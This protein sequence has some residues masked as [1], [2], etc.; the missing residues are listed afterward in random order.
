MNTSGEEERAVL[1]LNTNSPTTNSTDSSSSNTALSSTQTNMDTTLSTSTHY[2][3]PSNSNKTPTRQNQQAKAA[4]KAMAQQLCSNQLLVV[5]PPP[6]SS[7]LSP[8]RT[9]VVVNPLSQFQHGKIVAS[10]ESLTTINTISNKSSSQ[11]Q[12]QKTSPNSSTTSNNNNNGTMPVNGS[13]KTFKTICSPN[14]QF[15]NDSKPPQTP[16]QQCSIISK[17]PTH[18]KLSNFDQKP[19]NLP[20]NELFKRYE[21]K[22]SANENSLNSFP[23][24]HSSSANSLKLQS[25][26]QSGSNNDELDCQVTTF[27]SPTNRNNRAV[28][29][30]DYFFKD[31]KELRK[32]QQPSP[33]QLINF[34]HVIS[35][36]IQMDD[37]SEENY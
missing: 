23:S 2:S 31:E 14:H 35:A 25:K 16:K 26:Q 36:N 22:K 34:K 18:Q 19:L 3:S 1:I 28:K 15:N 17:T 5:V 20:V 32:F 11:L 4:A 7:S 30:S 6:S 9:R 27:T 24:I 33:K 13:F 10:S 12:T 8:T 29:V 21:L 37:N